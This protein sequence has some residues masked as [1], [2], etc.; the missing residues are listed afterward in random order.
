MT[1][2]ADTFASVFGS[3]TWVWKDPRTCLT[4]PLWRRVLDPPVCVVLVLRAPGAVVSSV[5]RR[6]GI[7]TVYGTGLWHRY[8]RAAVR[9]SS[10]LPVVCVRFADLV[11]APADTVRRVVGDL[12]QLGVELGGDIATAAA[13]VQAQLVHDPSS[14]GVVARLTATTVALLDT[15]PDSS[16]A[17]TP[18]TWSEPRWVRPTLF[19][20]RAP[21]A[22]RARHGHPLTPE[23]GT[24]PARDRR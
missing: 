14:T 22:L 16:E 21:W 17:F 24:T 15:I 1:D 23:R 9:A 3:D 6:D 19:A 18:P 7:P 20:Y 8:V 12:A 11:A 5:K 10:G 2:M 4:F 13:S